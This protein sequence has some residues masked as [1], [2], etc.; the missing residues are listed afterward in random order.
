MHMHAAVYGLLMAEC[1]ASMECIDTAAASGWILDCIVLNLRTH[2]RFYC[3]TVKV[4]ASGHA[5]R[6]ASAE[7]YL[8]SWYITIFYTYMTMGTS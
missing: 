6:E 8:Y 2:I 3:A 5:G 1:V 7:I 4:S